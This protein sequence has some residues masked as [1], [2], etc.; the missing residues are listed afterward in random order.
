MMK[1]K[2]QRRKT[3]RL[4]ENWVKT[5][6]M[7]LELKTQRKE[8]ERDRSGMRKPRSGMEKQGVSHC[9]G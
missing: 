7:S 5:G 3:Y 4:K 2:D 6:E 1:K 8:R 9:G